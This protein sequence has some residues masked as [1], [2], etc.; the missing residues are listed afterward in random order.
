MEKVFYD[1]KEI[2]ALTGLCM[3]TIDKCIKREHNPLPSVKLGRRVMIP[4]KEF[5]EWISK[6]AAGNKAG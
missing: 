5:N 1:R 6:E 3:T 4:V 2:M